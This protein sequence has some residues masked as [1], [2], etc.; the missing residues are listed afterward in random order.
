MRMARWALAAAAASALL[1]VGAGAFAAASGTGSGPTASAGAFLSDVASHL[2]VQPSALQSAIQQAD[3]DRI[4]GLQ[5]SGKISAAQAQKAI[6]SIQAGH[7][8]WMGQGGRPGR[9]LL[10]RPLIVAAAAG[11]LG[12]PAD[13][14]R[15]GLKGGRSLTALANGVPGKTP[16]GL[17]AAILSAVQSRLAQAVSAG[18]FTAARQQ[19]TLR[20]VQQRLPQLMTRTWNHAGASPAAQGASSTQ[21]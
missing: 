3:I 4:Q 1:L 8:R 7:W 18:Q 12:M 11:Y 16:A 15:S 13:Q 9:G 5:S 19:E 20:G 14:V 2:G 17:Q 10:G 21:G 6:T